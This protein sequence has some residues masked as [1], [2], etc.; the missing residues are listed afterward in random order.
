MSVKTRIDTRELMILYVLGHDGHLNAFAEVSD[1]LT[2]RWKCIHSLQI[3]VAPQCMY[4]SS[5]SIYVG[6]LDGTVTV[7]NW[8]GEQL[9][10]ENAI[11]LRLEEP[12]S[13]LLVTENSLI[14]CSGLGII[15]SFNFASQASTTL[16]DDGVIGC[17]FMVSTPRSLLIIK[18][19][20]L[21]IFN[22][23]QVTS[24]LLIP[25]SEAAGVLEASLNASGDL[26]RFISTDGALSCW[27]MRKQSL[28]TSES[29]QFRFKNKPLGLQLST[30]SRT[31]AV[32]TAGN[33]DILTLHIGTLSTRFFD[34]Q[35]ACTVWEASRYHP[36]DLSCWASRKAQFIRAKTEDD[37]VAQRFLAS[38]VDERLKTVTGKPEETLW[39]AYKLLLSDPTNR[40]QALR[41]APLENCPD[42][43]TASVPFESFSQA[44]CREG[45]HLRRCGATFVC[46]GTATA[47]EQ[48]E[49]CARTFIPGVCSRC[50]YCL[51]RIFIF[52]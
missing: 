20:T 24:S 1:D 33:K 48:C 27:D 10:K 30:S 31:A 29:A 14:A 50:A 3:G 42:C 6:D 35:D 18:Y 19:N 41:K 32:I 46:I 16:L 47:F 28:I 15:S 5:D 13:H 17:V 52:P 37:L 2:S 12:I 43:H 45:H 40:W 36:N 8:T 11:K 4:I 44:K 21:Y 7:L 49:D 34:A 39:E 22:D 23:G 38:A 25:E 51:G 9:V 26:L